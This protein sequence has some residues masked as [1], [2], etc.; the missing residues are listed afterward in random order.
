M[1]KLILLPALVIVLSFFASC[2][3][4]DMPKPEKSKT[5]SELQKSLK[6]KLVM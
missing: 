3:K 2:K 5:Q 6:E 4:E 1:K